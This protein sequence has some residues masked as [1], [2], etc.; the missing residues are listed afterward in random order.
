[1]GVGARLT[2][3]LADTSSV[4]RDYDTYIQDLD[5]TGSVVWKRN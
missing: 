3:V 2:R 1:M 4:K 5:S